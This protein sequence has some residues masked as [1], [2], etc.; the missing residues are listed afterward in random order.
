VDRK[1]ACTLAVIALAAFACKRNASDKQEH[2]TS[3]LIFDTA[4]PE[5]R[6]ALAIPVDF[7]LTE[8]NFAQWE[9][10]ENYLEELPRSALA[11]AAAPAGGNPIDRAVA[12]LEASPRARTAIERTGMSVRD[13]VLETIALAQ[14]TE[15][16][17]TAKSPTGHAIPAENFQFVQRYRARLLRASREERLASDQYDANAA[18]SDA[19]RS[20]QPAT[21]DSVVPVTDSA[22]TEVAPANAQRDSGQKRDSAQKRDTSDNSGRDTLPPPR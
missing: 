6:A 1:S 14:A 16:T 11:E 8:D 3:S 18:V 17:Q 5:A 19:G 15:A 13:F 7:R 20:E 9:A 12:R 2:L 21:V 4:S 22:P 10:A